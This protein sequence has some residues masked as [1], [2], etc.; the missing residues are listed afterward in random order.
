[1]KTFTIHGTPTSGVQA[2][3]HFV[4]WALL[5]ERQCPRILA[6]VQVFEDAVL[7]GDAPCLAQL[8]QCGVAVACSQPVAASSPIAETPR[9]LNAKFGGGQGPGQILDT[10]AAGDRGCAGVGDRSSASAAV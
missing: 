1:M 3:L 2:E 7:R 8:A 4:K 6:A 9:D 5:R 10:A